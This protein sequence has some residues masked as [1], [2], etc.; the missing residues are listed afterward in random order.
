MA[1]SSIFFNGKLISVP[2]S[3]SAIDASGLES[4]G[5]GANGIVAVLGTAEGGKP[6]TAM[7]EP[8]DFLRVNKPEKGRELFRSGDLREVMDMLFAPG[9]DPE[10]LG[11]AVQVVPMKCNP[12]TQSVAT[13]ANAQG[14]ALSLTSRDYGAFTEQINVSVATGTNQGKLL[15]I[16]F[17]DVTESVDDLGGDDIFTLQYSGGANGYTTMVAEVESGG[18]VKSTGT[19]T[20]LGK[21]GEIGVQ[22]VANSIVEVVSSAAGDTTQTATVYGLSAAGAAQQE[23]I[24]LT[25][26]TA[27]A[28]TLVFSKVYGIRLSAVAVGTVTVRPSPGGTAILVVTIGQLVRGATILDYGFVNNTT[29]TLVADGATTKTAIIAGKNV[30]GADQVEKFVLTGAVAVVGAANWSKIDTLAVVDVEAARTLTM[31]AVSARANVLVQT[32]AQKAADYYNAK[33]EIIAGPLTRGFIFTLL[34]GETSFLLSNLDRTVS[35]SPQ[36]IKDP[37]DGNF[38]ADLY[39]IVE[40]INANSQY[41]SAVASTGASGGAPSNTAQ[42]TFLT[43]GIEGTALASHYQAALNLL[44]KTRVNS[45]VVM[46]GDPAVHASLDAHCAYMGGVGRSERDGF[47]GL[48]NAGLTDVPSKTE[49]KTQIMDLNTRHIRACAQAVERYNTAGERAEFLPPFTAAVAAG[50]QAGSPVGTSLTFKYANILSFRQDSTWNPVDDAEEM[51]QAGLLFLE[52]VEGVGRRWVRNVTTH[53]SS[54]NIAFTEGSVNEAVNFATFNFRTN[55]EFAVGKK[56]FAGTV[57]AAKG[58]AINS[59]GLLVD[60]G[61]LVEWR[62]LNI[63]LI[64]DV[65]EVA[66]EI[67]PVIPINFVKNTLHLV[68]VRQAA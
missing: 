4:V 17:E 5:L 23:K 11:G 47:V 19:K 45:I 59:L 48:M 26:T 44:K 15:T 31:T 25:G 66:V 43:G 51:V 1:P 39:A 37:A 61:V 18:S 68:T 7:S 6:V 16:K 63:E 54:N 36:D 3:Y 27:H 58:V 29:V 42:P 49:A 9:K 12:A 8:K 56:G 60:A 64:V 55:M 41:V 22:M 33:Q 52:Q 40:W 13:L 14:N 34:T 35:G 62:S 24:T 2:G 32:T 57:N 30:A 50:M 67:A 28:G 65:L 53:L 20:T 10:I 21:D 38:K 46:T